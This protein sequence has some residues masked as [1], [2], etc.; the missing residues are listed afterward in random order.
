MHFVGLYIV[1]SSLKGRL[2]GHGC[3]SVDTDIMKIYGSL[4]I[5]SALGP[6]VRR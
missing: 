3:L 1:C 2:M 5:A 4:Q 6:L